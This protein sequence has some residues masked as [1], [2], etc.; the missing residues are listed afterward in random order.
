MA[1]LADLQQAKS[2]PLFDVFRARLDGRP[3]YVKSV[4]DHANESAR[5]GALASTWTHS[6]ET[7]VFHGRHMGWKDIV[8]E[9]RPGSAHYEALLHAEYTVVER[10]RQHWNHPGAQL[11]RRRGDDL[12]AEGGDVCLVIPACEGTPLSHLS[13]REQREWIPDMLP[14]LWRALAHCPHGDLSPDNLLIDPTRRFFRVLDPGVRIHGPFYRRVPGGGGLDFESTL[15]TTNTAHYPLLLPEHGPDGP[16]LCE[17]Y[18]GLLARQLEAYSHSWSP[19]LF[20]RET[21]EQRSVRV[22][23][24][25]ADLIA[26]GAMYAFALTGTPLSALLKLDAPLWSGGWDYRGR[27]VLS[28]RRRQYLEAIEGGELLR[29]LQS[30]GATPAEGELCVRLIALRIWSEEDLTR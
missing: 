8:E 4:A 26:I 5:R 18:A 13:P 24:A 2:G 3:V 1:N 7:N 25:A 20:R 10:A 16:R 12:V 6:N 21:R 19:E 11:M 17:P 23:P 22:S 9:A 29:S 14:P 28:T 27:D 15:F 30:A